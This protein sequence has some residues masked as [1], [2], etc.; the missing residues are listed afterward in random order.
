[1]D[2]LTLVKSNL[3]RPCPPIGV[4]LVQALRITRPRLAVPIVDV[5]WEI[6][7]KDASEDITPLIQGDL[8]VATVL[9]AFNF[10]VGG[11]QADT[12]KSSRVDQSSGVEGARGAVMSA[13][14]WG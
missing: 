1:M 10:P 3:K 5:G 7:R 4:E 9:H 12:K 6:R 14:T 13:L 8:G 11:S 2:R